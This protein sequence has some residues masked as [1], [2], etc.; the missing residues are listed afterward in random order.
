M[1]R[2]PDG[3]PPPVAVQ[4]LRLRYAKRGRLRFSSHRDFQRAFER[5]IRRAGVPIAFS[6][7]FNP[8]PKISYAGAAPTGTASEA[9]YLEIAVVE[10]CDPD[11]VR[12]ALDE[13][14]PPGLDVLEVVEARGGSLPDR[15]TA[16]IWRVELPTLTPGEARTAVARFLAAESVPVE[17]VMKDGRRQLDARVPVL[18]LTVSD[19][20][21]DDAP[22]PSDGPGAGPYAILHMVV[23]HET[24]SVRPDDVLTG[25]RQVADLVPPASE[26]RVTRLAQ[27]LLDDDGQVADP[28]APDREPVAHPAAAPA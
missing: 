14:L 20:E 19:S 4:R 16:S 2:T 10:L 13:S 7:G 12:K 15:I 18:S 26:A 11:A 28:L 9:E 8:H 22:T 6:A 21:G 25:L 23:R 5:A 17:R 1:A 3:P 27:G 24:P